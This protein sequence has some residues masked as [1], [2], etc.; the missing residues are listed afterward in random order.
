MFV[1][2]F[3]TLLKILEPHTT[4]SINTAGFFSLWWRQGIGI[5]LFTLKEQCKYFVNVSLIFCC[6][7]ESLMC[8]IATLTRW[9][10]LP[11]FLESERLQRHSPFFSVSFTG[12]TIYTCTLAR[13]LCIADILFYNTKQICSYTDLSLPPFD[14]YNLYGNT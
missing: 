3:M 5:C 2:L 10:H 14:S 12:L 11:S 7:L 8:I 13:P 9:T 6:R 1:I 4:K